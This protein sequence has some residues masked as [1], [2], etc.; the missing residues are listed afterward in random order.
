MTTSS[1]AEGHGATTPSIQE[2][3]LSYRSGFVAC[4]R[5]RAGALRRQQRVQRSRAPGFLHTGSSAHSFEA[6]PISSPPLLQPSVATAIRPSCLYSYLKQL[7]QAS[8]ASN[9]FLSFYSLPHSG[10][11]WPLLFFLVFISQEFFSVGHP[12]ELFMVPIR[13]AGRLLHGGG[14]DSYS[15]IF[16]TT[17]GERMGGMP[18]PISKEAERMGAPGCKRA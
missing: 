16:R 6:L 1:R 12:R 15:C 18:P 14:V 11:A 10:E 7:L 2:L 13:A 5:I 8:Q 17:L 9:H 3:A 4:N